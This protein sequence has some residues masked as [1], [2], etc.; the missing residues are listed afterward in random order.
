[1]IGHDGVRDHLI[2]LDGLTKEL[3]GTRR[4][5]VLTQQDVNDHA[6]LVDRSVEVALLAL[7]EQ[8]HFVY[9]PTPA[10]LTTLA[11]Y[12]GSQLRSERLDQLRTV[13]CETSRSASSSS[14]WRLDSG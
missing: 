12:L 14:T 3:L 5:A 7:T 11:S 9:E 2:P 6:S 10:D 4:V 1:M 8:E 13:R